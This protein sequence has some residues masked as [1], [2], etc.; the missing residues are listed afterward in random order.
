MLVTINVNNVLHERSRDS[1]VQAANRWGVEYVELNNRHATKYHPTY[2]KLLLFELL[3]T[4]NIFFVDADCLIMPWC[5]NPFEVL[6]DSAV[7]RADQE[8]LINYH[9]IVDHINKELKA[10]NIKQLHSYFNSGV[11]KLNS[12]YQI[13][14]NY[15]RSIYNDHLAWHEQTPMNIALVP[16]NITFVD[17]KWN[18]IPQNST[19]K[20]KYIYHFAGYEDK[21]KA[22]EDFQI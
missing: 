17:E 4:D 20:T 16:S 11:F 9:G 5:P 13:A 3:S 2:L 19:S 15:A 14:L 22:I 6:G 1:F 8:R 21:F 12:K 18:Y 10:F 7:V